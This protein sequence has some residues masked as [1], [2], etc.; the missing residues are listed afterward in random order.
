M[1]THPKP[2]V[3]TSKPIQTKIIHSQ[4]KIIPST[5]QAPLPKQTT[6]STLPPV[7]HGI[8]RKFSPVTLPTPQKEVRKSL[9]NPH[10]KI[11][12]TLPNFRFTLPPD[13][14]ENFGNL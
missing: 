3:S 8:L 10:L 1:P 2:Q 13:P 9:V 12:Q 6:I 5:I 14:K 11:P 7:P 4:K